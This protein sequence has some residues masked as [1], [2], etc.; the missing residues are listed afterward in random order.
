LRVIFIHVKI[1]LVCENHTLRVE[2]HTG[3]GSLTLRVETNLVEI[4]L[5]VEITLCM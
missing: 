4:T 5:R 1:T 2:P 3:C